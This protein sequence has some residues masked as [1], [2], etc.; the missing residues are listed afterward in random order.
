MEYPSD[1]APTASPWS[2][3]YDEDSNFAA[4]VPAAVLTGNAPSTCTSNTTYA[5][6]RLWI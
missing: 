5:V 1:A 4:S 3:D 6:Q 2:D